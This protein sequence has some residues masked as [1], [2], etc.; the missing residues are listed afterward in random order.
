MDAGKVIEVALSSNEAY[1]PGLMVTAASIAAN[2]QKTAVVRF[3]ILDGGICD[4]NYMAFERKVSQLNPNVSFRRFKLDER[5]VEGFPLWRGNTLAYARYAIPKLLS[6]CKYAVYCDTDTFWNIDIEELWNLRGDTKSILGVHDEKANLSAAKW[7]A[8]NGY[9]YVDNRYINAG[10]ML[11]NLEWFRNEKVID[12]CRDI[13]L[14]HPDILYP[15]QCALN[16]IL[17]DSLKVIDDKWM[18]FTIHLK[19]GQAWSR[20]VFHLASDLPWR[21][22][23]WYRPM[24]LPLW[25]WYSLYGALN[26][27]GVLWSMKQFLSWANIAQMFSM[28]LLVNIPIVRQALGAFAKCIKREA[29]WQEAVSVALI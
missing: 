29:A 14:K 17:Q 5:D 10:V 2:V 4:A 20:S 3:N 23:V 8:K 27:R 24:S 12:G 7:W 11:M 21:K 15:D 25:R 16:I 6:E 18:R 9:T 1:F 22:R 26:G 19:R 28:F 13:I